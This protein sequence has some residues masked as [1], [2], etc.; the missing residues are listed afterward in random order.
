L[1]MKKILVDTNAY[2]S[3]LAGDRAV[4]DALAEAGTVYLSIFVLGELYAGFKGGNRE[5]ANINIL[6]EFISKP[7]VRI[8]D[9]NSETA[10]IFGLLKSTL[11]S[12]GTPL[13]INDVW[14]AAHAMEVGAMIVTYDNHFEKIP[15]IRLWLGISDGQK[16]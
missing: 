15:G 13:P 6:R 3:F 9:A 14:I 8:L 5:I 1:G 4:L 12:A 11:K 2:V 16:L 7:T 10:E